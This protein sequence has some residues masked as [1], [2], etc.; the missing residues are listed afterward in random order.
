[1]YK[2]RL[3]LVLFAV[4][5]WSCNFLFIWEWGP[6]H[7]LFNSFKTI[8]IVIHIVKVTFKD[9]MTLKW[10]ELN[11]FQPRQFTNLLKPVKMISQGI[12]KVGVP[13]C[14]YLFEQYYWPNLVVTIFSVSRPEVI[15]VNCFLG[16]VPLALIL[17]GQ[18]CRDCRCRDAWRR[19]ILGNK[20]RHVKTIQE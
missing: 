19:E 11:I 4:N 14:K 5:I 13:T 2:N 16:W 6:G 3:E 7:L 10:L 20:V 8:R 9:K 15:R 1:M 17:S 12:I 18:I